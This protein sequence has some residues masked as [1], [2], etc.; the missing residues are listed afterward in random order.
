M[1]VPLM[2]NLYETVPRETLEKPKF[3]NLTIPATAVEV[4]WRTTAPEI[5]L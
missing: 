2:L 3:V 4:S 1:E 5:G